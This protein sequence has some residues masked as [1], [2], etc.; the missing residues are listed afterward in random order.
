M[1]F[2]QMKTEAENNWLLRFCAHHLLP[3]CLQLKLHEE[4]LYL[5]PILSRCV[6]IE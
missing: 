6:N 2:S 3:Q 4:N 5:S 1:M